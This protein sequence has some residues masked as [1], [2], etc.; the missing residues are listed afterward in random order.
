MC[1]GGGDKGGEGRFTTGVGGVGRLDGVEI[2]A[3]GL[4]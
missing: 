3:E 1:V 4:P 2:W